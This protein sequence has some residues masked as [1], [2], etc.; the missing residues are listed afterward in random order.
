[1]QIAPTRPVN[2]NFGNAQT[3]NAS[4]MDGDAMAMMVCSWLK[5]KTFSL[6][7]FITSLLDKTSIKIL[8]LNPYYA[9]IWA[10]NY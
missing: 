7:P 1:M 6:P 8:F 4:P 2:P 5:F 10:I 9:Q 3:T